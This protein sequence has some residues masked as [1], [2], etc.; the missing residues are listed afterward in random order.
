MLEIPK[1]WQGSR[2]W[3]MTRARIEVYPFFLILLLNLGAQD[4]SQNLVEKKNK[5]AVG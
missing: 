5:T 3:D 4:L 1:L 2:F